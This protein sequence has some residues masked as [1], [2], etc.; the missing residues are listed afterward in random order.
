MV[1]I[2]L[3]SLALAALACPAGA[4]YISWEGDCLPEEAGWTRV[5]GDWTGP[6]HGTGAVRTIADGVM[7]MDSLYDD[8]VYDFAQINAELNPA[9]GELFVAEWRLA[10]DELVGAIPGVVGDPGITVCSDDRW[11]AYF[12]YDGESLIGYSGLHVPVTPGEFHDYRVTSPNM[13]T[14][15]LFIDGELVYKGSFWYQLLAS[16]ATFGDAVQGA[17]SLARWDYVRLYTIP[18]PTSV[19]LLLAVASCCA[20][21]RCSDPFLTKGETK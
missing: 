2:C 16:R 9:P 19:L 10:I 11:M 6:Y 4:Y 18:E 7:T 5:W 21:R 15:D 13:R 12:E 3:I 20:R 17:G 8:G 14:Y 1:R